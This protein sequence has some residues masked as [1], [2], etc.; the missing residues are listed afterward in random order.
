[1]TKLFVNI[2]NVYNTDQMKN[3]CMCCRNYIRNTLITLKQF[4]LCADENKTLIELYVYKTTTPF[5]IMICKDEIDHIHAWLTCGI[6]QYDWV[7]DVN[8]LSYLYDVKTYCESTLLSINYM[9]NVISPQNK[10]VQTHNGN[11]LKL[12]TSLLNEFA[13][14]KMNCMYTCYDRKRIIPNLFVCDSRNQ[15]LMMTILNDAQLSYML[16][17]SQLS[18]RKTIYIDNLLVPLKYV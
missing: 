12:V 11:L 2:G 18:V 6:K 3:V 9:W 13:V 4:P 7:Y 16:S 17:F 14:I 8:F 15:I 10:I 5:L 1:M